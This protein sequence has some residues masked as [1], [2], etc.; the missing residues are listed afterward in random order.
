MASSIVAG[1]PPLPPPPPSSWDEAPGAAAAGVTAGAH[2]QQRSDPPLPTTTQ[3]A[4]H[5]PPDFVVQNHVQQ[6][7]D[8]TCEPGGGGQIG[9]NGKGNEHEVFA[10]V[11]IVLGP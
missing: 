10:A 11:V 6:Q 2:P 8:E 4:D 5:F 1:P 7:Y 3:H 9:R